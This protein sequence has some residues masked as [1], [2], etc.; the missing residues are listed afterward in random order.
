MRRMSTATFVQQAGK[1]LVASERLTWDTLTANGEGVM[2]EEKPQSKLEDK[3]AETERPKPPPGFRKFRKMLKKVV[4]A[5]PMRKR[6]PD[7]P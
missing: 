1:L 2:A 3:D 6:E 7:T 5:P 4:N